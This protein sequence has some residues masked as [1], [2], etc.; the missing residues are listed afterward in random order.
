MKK[1]L[2][3]VL[4]AAMAVTL[5][6]G[7]GNNKAAKENTPAKKQTI[8]FAAQNDN[9]EATKKLIEEFN[10]SQDK[11]E[12]VWETFTN[13]SAQMHDQL[14]TSLSSGKSDYDVLSLDVVWAGEFGAAGY[15][16]ALDSM[17][18]DSDMKKTDF[19]SGSMASGNY[20][21]KQYTLPFFPDLGLLYYR[22]DIVSKEDGE[23]LVSGD[24]TYADLAEMAKKYAGTKDAEIGYVY[25]SKQYE[26]LTCNVT[27]FTG[28]YKDIKGGLETMKSFTDSDFT[29]DDILNYTEG[30]THNAFIQ[31][32]A[33][34]AR[35]WPY[36]YGMVK[37]EDSPLTVEQINVAPL[38]NGGTVGGWL[39]AISNKS[40]NQEGAWEFLKF[41]AGEKGQK[42]MSTVGGYLPGYNKLLEDKEVLESN[43]MLSYEGF[44]KAL[45]GTI[46]RPVSAEY[47]KTSDAIQLNVHSYLSG[48]KSLEEAV[49]AVEDALK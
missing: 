8:K 47:S 44:K 32:K 25:Q 27:E 7:C 19:N 17:M 12:V 24:Y 21:G 31:G 45:S 39:L 16:K 38:P 15:I 42:I 36:Q 11:Y 4:A 5:F 10:K 40:K 41:T 9:T 35:N 2:S 22:S 48:G 18:K 6:S 3:T 28:S 23:K 46:S 30:E 33:V 20:K 13:D 37:S 14:I 49:K 43:P 29:P 1:I 34:F 26:G